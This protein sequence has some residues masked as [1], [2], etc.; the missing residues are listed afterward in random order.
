VAINLPKSTLIHFHSFIVQARL[1]L[2]DQFY[3]SLW[4][5]IEAGILEK[6]VEKLMAYAEFKG[7]KVESKTVEEDAKAILALEVEIAKKLNRPES[8]RREYKKM[9]NSK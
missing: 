7:I 5:K 3:I 8:Q 9:Y 2:P 6:T 4:D 1:S